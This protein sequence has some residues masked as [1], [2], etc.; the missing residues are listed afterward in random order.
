MVDQ[1][2]FLL[3]ILARIDNN[4][5]PFQQDLKVACVLLLPLTRACFFLFEQLIKQQMVRLQDSISECLHHHTLSN[6]LS[7]EIFKAHL[8]RIL[9]CSS[10]KASAWF[11]ARAIFPSF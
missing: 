4:T 5:F 11:I 7:H 9:S 10:P 2:P 3:E 1:R 8:A 6:M